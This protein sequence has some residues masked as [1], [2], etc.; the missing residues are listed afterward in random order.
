M[1]CYFRRYNA[2][3]YV[4][5][6]LLICKSNTK[7]KYL[8]KFDF[9]RRICNW[10]ALISV[11]L[12][13]NTTLKLHVRF[14]QIVEYT[15]LHDTRPRRVSTQHEHATLPALALRGASTTYITPRRTQFILAVSSVIRRWVTYIVCICRLK[16]KLQCIF[17]IFVII[18][19]VNGRLYNISLDQ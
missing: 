6:V 8:L 17:I 11:N 9:I 2:Y 3:I 18:W 12:F 15:H 4:I 5:I 14:E 7:F 1:S 16:L 10:I 19:L 13:E